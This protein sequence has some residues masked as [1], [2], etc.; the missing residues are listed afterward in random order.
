MFINSIDILLP[1]GLEYNRAF[2]MVALALFMNA[3]L[4]T[5]ERTQERKNWYY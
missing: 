4:L 3:A 1:N 5:I 2:R